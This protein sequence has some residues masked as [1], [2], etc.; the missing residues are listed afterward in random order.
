VSRELRDY[1]RQ[2]VADTHARHQA[3]D[4]ALAGSAA[5][6]LGKSTIKGQVIVDAVRATG[7][8]ALVLAHR[9]ELCDQ[10]TETIAE[11]AP[12]IPIGRIQGSRNRLDCPITVATT[13]TL[14]QYRKGRDDQPGTLPRLER[15]LGA[16][17]VPVTMVGYDEFHHAAA[18]SNARLLQAIGCVGPDATVPLLGVSATLTRSDKYHLGNL[19]HRREAFSYD[20]VF[21]I[22]NGY[23]VRPHGKVVVADHLDLTRAKVTAG[24]YQDGQLGEMVAQDA[25]QIVQAWLDHG[26]NRITAGFFPTRESARTILE[27]F[28]ARGVAAELVTGETPSG[29]GYFQR[30]SATRGTGIYGRLA[31]GITR[32]LVGVMVTT[33]GW[34]CP[35]VSCILMG[36]PTRIQALYQQIVG[37]ALRRVLAW[38]AKRYGW[39]MPPDDAL[40][41][42]IVGA[43]WGQ[44]LV[45]LSDLVPGA[46]VDYSALD[47]VPCPDCRKVRCTCQAGTNPRDPNGGRR[48]LKGP[49][50][51]EDFDLLLE[52]A[53]D[54][55]L[56][57][58]AGHPVLV[59][60]GLTRFAVIMAERGGTYRV[61]H[62]RKRGAFDQQRIGAGLTLDEARRA[63]EDWAISQAP[64]LGY[65]NA[66]WRTRA[67]GAPSGRQLSNASRLDIAAPETYPAGMLADLIAVRETSM[68]MDLL[69]H[70]AAAKR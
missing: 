22:A 50:F 15:W 26:E 12:G 30:G 53:G 41:L 55:W 56:A 52:E 58:D 39:E 67:K 25:D 45:S 20:T 4:L 44:K 51:Y 11:L 8:R 47:S 57:T 27:A 32:V 28:L 64:H 43:S 62:L 38:M 34:D 3:G 7:G 2:A 46:E 33:E 36:R 37:R 66:V 21:G 63:A 61:G 31:K 60:D 9:T 68:R 24:D 16:S 18:P 14:G 69:G 40:I 54:R 29:D 10:L 59:A 35:P 1:Q 17:D 23:L 48:R 5:T 6:G 42:D 49:A 70:G 65:R 19:V 13:N